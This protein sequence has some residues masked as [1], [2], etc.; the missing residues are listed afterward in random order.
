MSVV[1][2]QRIE[3]KEDNNFVFIAGSMYTA[4]TSLLKL[5]GQHRSSLMVDAACTCVYY[6]IH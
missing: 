5:C 6:L 4:V 1:L 3:L 2:P